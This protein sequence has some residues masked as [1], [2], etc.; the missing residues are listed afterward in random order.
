MNALLKC[1]KKR[2]LNGSA[3]NQNKCCFSTVLRPQVVDFAKLKL[4]CSIGVGGS[5]QISIV[6]T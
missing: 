4:F 3:K 1:K 2:Y 5:T 6:S